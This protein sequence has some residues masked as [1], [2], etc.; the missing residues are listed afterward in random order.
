MK[1]QHT[2]VSKE[3]YYR[4]VICSSSLFQELVL[5]KKVLTEQGQIMNCH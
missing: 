1:W 4:K 5:E 2:L 3:Y